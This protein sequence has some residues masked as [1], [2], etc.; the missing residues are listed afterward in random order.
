MKFGYT[1]IYVPDV[2]ASLSFF[3]QA[4]GFA[5]R[6]LHESRTYGEL[7]TGETTLAFAAHELAD[8]NF[9]GGHVAASA[10]AEPLGMEVAFVTDDL[11][12]AHA[13]ALA[14]GATEMS[15]PVSKPWGQVVSYVRCPDGT[16]V[17]LCT[18]MQG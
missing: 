2:A 13:R 10:S 16:L 11:A 9:G 5:R 18:P 12:A 1:I 4:F 7:D 6:F 8:A 3:E 17:E 15:A 14:A